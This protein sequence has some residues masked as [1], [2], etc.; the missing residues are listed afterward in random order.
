MFE[1]APQ[2]DNPGIISLV[3]GFRIENNGLLS[4]SGHIILSA[5]GDRGMH[6]TGP[7]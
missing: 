6:T 7:Q 2:L 5:R 3:D 1:K 4:S